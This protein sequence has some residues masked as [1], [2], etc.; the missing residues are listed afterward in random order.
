[1]APMTLFVSNM[2]TPSRGLLLLVRNISLDIDIKQVNLLAG[3]HRRSEFSRINPRCC[4]PTLIDNDG[5][6]EF[7]LWESKAIMIYLAEK[8]QRYG[9]SLYPKCIKTRAI[10][11][12]RLFHDASELYVRILDIAN[13][14]FSGVSSTITTQHKE[15]LRKA[16]QILELFLEGHDFF[17]GNHMT[18]CDYAYLASIC[19]LVHFGFDISQFTHINQWYKRMSLCEGFKEC[20][21]GAEEFGMMVK[22]KLSNSF[23]D[24]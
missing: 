18:I 6:H 9:H 10:I 14:A 24:V 22:G 11:H 13:L 21:T 16:L 7:I 1:M 8:C 3:E 23:K 5:H 2:S 12:Q 4:V 15:N 17:A 20:E 19:T